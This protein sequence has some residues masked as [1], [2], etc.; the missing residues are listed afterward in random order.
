MSDEARSGGDSSPK[1]MFERIR[2]L[3]CSIDQVTVIPP[4]LQTRLQLVL[5]EFKD[6]RKADTFEEV[7]LQ[8]SQAVEHLEDLGVFHD[9]SARLGAGLAV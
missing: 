7:L 5:R 1:D 4:D 3:P 2:A 9:V 6:A 8:T